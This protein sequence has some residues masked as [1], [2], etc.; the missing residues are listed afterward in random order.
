MRHI[1]GGQI[2]YDKNLTKQSNILKKKQILSNGRSALYFILKGIKK[3][4]KLVYLP[5]YLCES[6]LQPIKELNL[7]YKFY[8]VEK[9]FNFK[10]PYKKNSAMIFLN[11][12]GIENKELKNIKNNPKYNIFYI[13]DCTHDIFNKKH[14]LN[15]F[16]KKDIFR[17]AS[18]K[19]YIPFPVGAIT[20]QDNLNML[21]L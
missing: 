14:D 4:I 2:G 7:N 9:N 13:K 11:Y 10:L 12:F 17:F 20:N 5:S 21:N 18:I 3:K 6:I 8:K 19:K 1:I 15:D 16:N